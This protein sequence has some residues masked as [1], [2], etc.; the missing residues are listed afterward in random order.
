M[1]GWAFS[2]WGGQPYW[3]IKTG[4]P[5][6]P[7]IDGGMIR[8]MGPASEGMQPVNAFVCTV[9]VADLDAAMTKA[10]ESGGAVA[11][12]RMA[13]AG[14]GWLGYVKDTE[15]NIIGMMQNDPSAK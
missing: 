12:P 4:E 11:L 13:V 14:I 8:R 10:T 6:Q 9:D 5:G 7:G 3:L 15:G 2:H 1:F